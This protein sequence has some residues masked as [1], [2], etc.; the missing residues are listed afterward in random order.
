MHEKA[1]VD[2]RKSVSYRMKFARV[3]RVTASQ[4]TADAKRW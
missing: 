4:A 2:A 1:F 3:I